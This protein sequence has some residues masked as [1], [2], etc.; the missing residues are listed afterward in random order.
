MTGPLTGIRVLEF[1]G[2][3]PVPFA[4]MMLA[5]MGADVIRLGR[6]GRELPVKD[7]ITGRGRPRVDADLKS[8]EDLADVIALAARADILIEGFRP[9]V[10]ER[11]RLG[12]EPLIN[13]N[14][15][16]VYGRA[17]GWGQDGP[18]ADRA[19]HDINYIAPTGVLAAIGTD[20]QAIPPLNLV[21]D[22]GG[23]ALYLV[24]GVL[25]A[26]LLARSNGRGQVVDCAMSEGA[27]SLM[28]FIYEMEADGQWTGSRGTN[29]LDGGAPFYGVFRCADGL[30]LAIGAIE[31]PFLRDMLQVFGLPPELA[32][33]MRDPDQWPH[34]RQTMT[35]T[36][37]TRCRG[38]WLERAAGLDPCITP[39]LTMAD[40]ADDPHLHAREAF[41]EIGGVIQPAPAPRF[42]QT[43][44]R[45]LPRPD[46]AWS[47]AQARAKWTT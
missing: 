36:V 9:G 27:L 32:I 21:G 44:S 23:G 7:T 30:D 2:L 5:D 1:E 11:L 34:L 28:S 13:A 18:Y 16:L 42:S 12:P 35:L 25:A 4:G 46:G 37:A 15:A 43:P 31:A 6:P 40:A 26:C 38:E 45:A 20:T 29:M 19:G 39:V 17:T 10:M 8:P 24:A 33:A 3:G 41:V 47:L 22:F 14:P